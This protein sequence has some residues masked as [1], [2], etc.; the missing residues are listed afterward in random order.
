VALAEKHE[1]VEALALDGPGEALGV[2]VQVGAARRQAAR[3][4]AG[5]GEES[6]E[7]WTERDLSLMNRAFDSQNDQTFSS[8][9]FRP[10]LGS[11]SQV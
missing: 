4:D 2:S 7:L 3:G 5:G 9:N 6:S 11:G 10:E 8:S 1:F